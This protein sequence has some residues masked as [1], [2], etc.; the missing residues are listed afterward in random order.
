MTY[1]SKTSQT[2][3]AKWVHRYWQIRKGLDELSE[4]NLQRVIG[5][6]T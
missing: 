5:K 6:K 4:L 2:K 3:L 1:I